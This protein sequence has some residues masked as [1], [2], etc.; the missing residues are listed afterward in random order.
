MLASNIGY[1]ILFITIVALSRVTY[2]PLAPSY[3]PT[4][5]PTPSLRSSPSKV[6]TTPGT[7]TLTYAPSHR[8]DQY[9]SS[10]SPRQ[11]ELVYPDQTSYWTPS[12]PY[13]TRIETF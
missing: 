10:Y 9:E 1:I 11:T 5:Q 6:L 7:Q 3:R 2:R 4:F 12:T 13:F 8:S